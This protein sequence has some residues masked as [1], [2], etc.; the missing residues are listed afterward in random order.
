[1]TDVVVPSFDDAFRKQFADLIEWRRD[2]RRFRPD[3]ID[4]AVIEHLV[5]LACLSPSVGN[6]QP[7]RF[8]LVDDA[9]RRARVRDS[10]AACNA[11]AL[12]SYAGEQAKLY[13]SLKLSGLDVAPVHLAVYCETR[14]D[15]GHG[16]GRQ[17]IPQTLH[18]SVAGAVQ[19]FALAARAMGVGVGVVSILD[20]VEIA[21]IL[22][23]PASW[24]LVSYLCVGYPEEEH[25]DPE[26]V[27]YGWQNRLPVDA[28]IFR[29]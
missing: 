17:T 24:D 1:M 13:A 25:K 6:A 22:D 26:L 29:R 12:N 19:T 9:A 5:S 10:Y 20:P 28:V 4:P 7:W 18:Y 3:G 14:P 23:I 15:E 16:L 11:D 8:V 2:V 21:A 27:R